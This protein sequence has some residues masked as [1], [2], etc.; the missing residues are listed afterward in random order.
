MAAA[1]HVVVLAAASR[2]ETVACPLRS[3]PWGGHEDPTS[4]S[5][6]ALVC[7]PLEL[8]GPVRAD[9]VIGNPVFTDCRKVTLHKYVNINHPD[10][11]RDL[12]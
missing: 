9:V 8:Q 3:D 10:V 12:G 5:A 6:W 2:R 11:V 4:S 1:R 7:I